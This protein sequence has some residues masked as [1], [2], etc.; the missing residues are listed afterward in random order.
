M[1]IVIKPNKSLLFLN[2]DHE[3]RDSF[4]GFAINVSGNV[5]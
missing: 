3:K 5:V 4:N 1:T 2:S